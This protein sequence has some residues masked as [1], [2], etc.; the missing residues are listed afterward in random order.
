MPDFTSLILR[1]APLSAVTGILTA[2]GTLAVCIA[3]I[4]AEGVVACVMSS[5][6]IA[7][8]PLVPA[9][10]DQWQRVRIIRKVLDKIDSVDDAAKLL[11]AL[12]PPSWPA[13]EA[14]SRS[15]HKP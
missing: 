4:P 3:G 10:I 8:G 11:Q 13:A 14:S 6:I 2:A 9:L 12:A 1:S 5:V 15:V 7:V